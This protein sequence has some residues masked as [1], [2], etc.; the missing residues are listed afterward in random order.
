MLKDATQLCNVAAQDNGIFFTFLICI[1][2]RT[3]WDKAMADIIFS[4]DHLIRILCDDI[5]DF[6]CP[7]VNIFRK[8]FMAISSLFF[9]MSFSNFWMIGA[10]CVVLVCN[11]FIY[12]FSCRF[13]FTNSLFSLRSSSFFVSDCISSSSNVVVK[14]LSSSTSRF[15]KNE[16]IYYFHCIT[17]HKY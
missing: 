14:I 17:V 9:C 3:Q 2:F 10:F 1:S 12:K 8:A 15:L 4:D 7:D 5:K 13:T 6:I 11:S 16:I